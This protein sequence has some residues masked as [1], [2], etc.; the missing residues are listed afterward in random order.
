MEYISFQDLKF[1]I[2]RNKKK[3]FAVAVVVAL[4]AG[5]YEACSLVKENQAAVHTGNADYSS[6]LKTYNEQK[7][8]LAEI[9]GSLQKS[10]TSYARALKED[11]VMSIDPYH[12][13]YNRIICVFRGSENQKGEMVSAWLSKRS[14]MELFGKQS[15]LYQKYADS[16]INVWSIDSKSVAL[17][18]Y[19][20]DGVNPD[21]TATK[22]RQIIKSEADESG[23]GG[24]SVQVVKK[25]DS[26]NS[27]LYDFQ[28]ENA[29]RLTRLSTQ[30]KSVRESLRTL[31]APSKGDSI[32]SRKHM[33]AA[34]LKYSILGLITGILIGILAVLY[35]VLNRG[36]IFSG[37]QL[38]DWMDADC[39][40]CIDGEN[41]EQAAV[42][43][44]ESIG[45]YL[46]KDAGIMICSAENCGIETRLMEILENLNTYRYIL[47]RGSD[48]GE[49]IRK[50]ADADGVILCVSKG[51][52]LES[53]LKETV[54]RILHADKALLGYIYIDKI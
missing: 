21:F 23:I 3:I 5:V 26:C 19:K 50:L 48:R 41:L 40:A 16:I 33:A 35:R 27:E 17:D 18:I 37:N 54:K 29:E 47:C 53:E 9:A 42:E 36:Y 28:L 52:S 10:Y 31:E 32:V 51:K 46:E 39:L 11:P 45:L 43:I 12:C 2:K 4:A 25:K 6:E 38:R 44:H 49:L 7:A 24:L 30:L 1:I 13:S 14:A 34:I 22:V 8:D 15:E 20:V